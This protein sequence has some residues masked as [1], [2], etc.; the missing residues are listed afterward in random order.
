MRRTAIWTL[1]K[2]IPPTFCANSR[3]FIPLLA[4]NVKHN[5]S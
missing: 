4:P 3:N 2:S 5:E 1:P